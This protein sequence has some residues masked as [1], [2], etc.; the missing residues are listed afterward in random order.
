MA[1]DAANIKSYPG[2]GTTWD[3]LSFYNNDGTLAGGPNYTST[4]SGSI[5]FDGSNDNVSIGTNGFSFGSSPGTLSAWAKT[6]DRNSTRTIVSY[7]NAATNQAR[8]LGIGQNNFYFS[9][10]GS[11]I[12][13]S[14]LSY[15]TWFNLVGVYDGTDASM[16][17]NGA[18]VA[19][20][21]DRSSW[22]TV[23][24]NAGVGKNV[25]GNEYWTGNISQVQI[26]N[27]ALSAAEIQQNYNAIKGRYA[28]YISGEEPLIITVSVTPSST[29]EDGVT[30][31]VYT[32]T[33]DRIVTSNVTVNYTIS[34]TATNGV[35]YATISNSVT[36]LA[37]SS[38]A[39]VTVNPT[40]DTVYEDDETVILTITSGG[41]DI[42][43]PSSATGTIN[44]DE[45]T[46]TVSVAPSSTLEDG[47]TNLVYTFTSDRTLTS[48]LTVNYTI[49]GTA[50]NG[51]DYA[52]I[53]TS[54]N[55][56]S[57]NSTATVTVNPTT[58]STYENDETV[59]LTIASNSAYA[60]GSPSSA[61]GTITNDDAPDPGEYWIVN[62]KNTVVS[63]ER[64]YGR[65]IAVD[66]SGNVYT[67]GSVA[68]VSGMLITKHNSFGTNIWK[69]TLGGVSNNYTGFGI[70]VDSS[71]NV[72]VTGEVSQ[73]GEYLVF[74]A[75]YTSIGGLSWQR[76]LGAGAGEDIA[77]DGLGNVYISGYSDAG[78][79]LVAKYS[80]G[81]T[82]SWQN[83]SPDNINIG[84][85]IAVDSSNNVYVTGTIDF[86]GSVSNIFVAKYNGAT[87]A[88]VWQRTLRSS[89]STID[90]GGLAIAVDGSGNVYITGYTN[91]SGAGS[92]DILIAKYDTDGLFKWQ[93]TLGSNSDDRGYG[94]A[95][96]SSNN[97][98]VTGSNSYLSSSMV[99]AKY[100]TFGTNLWKRNLSFAEV[101]LK[102]NIAVD[103][104]GRVH[105]TGGNIDF[106]SL[107]IAKLP[108]DGTLTGTYGT[109]T[110]ATSAFTLGEPALTSEASSSDVEESFQD[111]LAPSP[112]LS[113]ADS[114][115]TS[116]ITPVP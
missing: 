24:N 31:I 62:I 84:Y 70:A 22:N 37:G 45:P 77:V 89:N 64:P 4:S 94:I 56:L 38:S 92:Y 114:T 16:Y 111:S 113:S 33:S 82:L 60:I 13:A 76:T 96:D 40:T 2:S 11:S 52:T 107:F 6:R 44:N 74:V 101:S 25:S 41:Y 68:G 35:D 61:T 115:F 58:D 34:G 88:N 30:N 81:G 48:T 95:V 97:V 87:G 53:G 46:I 10:Y 54:V 21:T 57:G 23:A 50:T 110:Y 106:D 8:F 1:L 42:G 80:S 116:S 69:K 93:R 17:I 39:T 104:F 9:G 14:G 36:I 47:V 83:N 51:V 109:L 108:T 75:K 55:I 3:D 26:Y 100:D 15:D 103:S 7:G 99:I 98:Y 66:G 90:D 73:G 86:V 18:L 79:L 28:T 72:Y 85:G 5:V 91:S 20:P 49:S 105:V 65:D 12:S 29:D 63:A 78:G 71:G 19:G 102:N 59:I 32:F 27:R 43:S 112:L 67:I